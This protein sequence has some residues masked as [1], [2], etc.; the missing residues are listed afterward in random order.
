[1]KNISQSLKDMTLR[2][3]VEAIEEDDAPRLDMLLEN[4]EM[5]DISAIHMDKSLMYHA[6]FFGSQK[7]LVVLIENGAKLNEGELESLKAEGDVKIVNILKELDNLILNTPIK[8]V[9]PEEMADLEPEPKEL[10]EYEPE[11]LELDYQEQTATSYGKNL[12]KSIALGDHYFEKDNLVVLTTYD[13]KK[14]M[15]NLD[16]IADLESVEEIE[17]SILQ[18]L[19]QALGGNKDNQEIFEK[20]LQHKLTSEQS[21]HTLASGYITFVDLEKM[22]GDITDQAEIDRRF[23]FITSTQTL[24][25]LATKMVSVDEI[26]N[27]KLYSI[28][29]IIEAKGLDSWERVVSEVDETKHTWQETLAQLMQVISD[30]MHEIPRKLTSAYHHVMEDKPEVRHLEDNKNKHVDNVNND[31]DIIVKR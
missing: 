29:D 13:D 30:M 26:I 12:L 2:Y 11:G 22:I 10:V 7:A 9:E 24:A 5:V 18:V 20:Y 14:I 19:F 21:L 16:E 31:K 28:D 4:K 25:L 23:D 15:F 17:S 3:V 27:E 8:Q 6:I 1:M